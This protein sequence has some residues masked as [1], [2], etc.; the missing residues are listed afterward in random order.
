M[1]VATTTGVSVATERFS[2]TAAASC[3]GV[4]VSIKRLGGNVGTALTSA[5]LSGVCAAAT[6]ADINVAVAVSAVT[7]AEGGI[8]VGKMVSVGEGEGVA[9]GVAK[10]VA[11]AVGTIGVRGIAM[12]VATKRVVPKS[13]AVLPPSPQTFSCT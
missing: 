11:E 9:V 8:G 5:A 6:V 3:V 4:A 10:K 12:G 2:A 1:N 13:L 7:V